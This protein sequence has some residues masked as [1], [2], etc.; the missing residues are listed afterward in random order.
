M[1]VSAT[2]RCREWRSCGNGRLRV[3]VV[4][5]PTLVCGSTA[6]LPTGGV[7]VVVA[8]VTLDDCEDMTY[9]WWILGVLAVGDDECPG[10]IRVVLLLLLPG[11]WE[12]PVGT[13]SGCGARGDIVAGA[14]VYGGTD[15]PLEDDD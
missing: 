5:A 2:A 4:A 12:T 8:V 14:T 11:C 9:G 7:V 3:V 15:W 13:D 1:S 6:V 10:T